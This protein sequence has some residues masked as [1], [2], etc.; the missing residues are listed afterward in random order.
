MRHVRPVLLVLLG[1]SFPGLWASSAGREVGGA[2]VDRFLARADESLTQYRALRRLTARNERFRKEGQL[3]AVTSL[4]P[5]G[6][7]HYEILNGSGSGLVRKRV[8]EPILR[9]EAR[10]LAE[11]AATRAALTPAN[12]EFVQVEPSVG[13]LAQLTIRPKRKDTLLVDG[14]VFVTPD[15]ADLIRIEGKLA[16]NPSFWTTRVQV[17]REYSRI[18]GVRVPVRVESRAWV[19]IV[20]VSTFVM[21]YEYTEINGRKVAASG[22]A[23]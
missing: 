23:Q 20:G 5:Q 19:R 17:S 18:A 2:L 21:T 1:L 7:F 8:L 15:E 10:A 11:G 16:K 12:Y 13:P 9:G 4:D 6:G 22:A 3:E 14:S